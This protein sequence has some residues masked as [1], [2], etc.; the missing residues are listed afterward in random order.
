MNFKLLI[1]SLALSGISFAQEMSTPA[2]DNQCR[3][4]AKEMAIKTYQNCVSDVKAARIE[5][6]R[7]EY[8]DKLDELKKQYEAQMQE[9][10]AA[11]GNSNVKPVEANPKEVKPVDEKPAVEDAK[12]VEQIPTTLEE[13]KSVQQEDLSLNEPKIVLKP[14]ASVQQDSKKSKQAK[15]K[16]A[17]KVVAQ[18]RATGEKGVKG[19][20]KTLPAKKKTV[21]TKPASEIITEN[22]LS[23]TAPI[24]VSDLERV[25]LTSAPNGEK[26]DMSSDKNVS[27]PDSDSMQ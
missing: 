6:I 9:L 11:N 13:P 17:T 7:K 24:Q 19:I 23:K 16:K 2:A 10:K 12:P 15:S 26:D 27:I 18:K 1:A 3:I 21:E 8:Q 25:Q 4:Q 5:E 14:A 20:A 22:Q